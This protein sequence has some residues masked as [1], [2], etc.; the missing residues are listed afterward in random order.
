M[1]PRTGDARRLLLLAA[2]VLL[3]RGQALHAHV[4]HGE[5]VSFRIGFQ[6]PIS[7]WDHV[8]ATRVSRP[9]ATTGRARLGQPQR[10]IPEN[11]ATTPAAC[12]ACG[13]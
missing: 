5:A 3:C 10:A 11:G 13:H 8:M 6:H 12:I 7:G 2:V 4:Q 9:R 1:K